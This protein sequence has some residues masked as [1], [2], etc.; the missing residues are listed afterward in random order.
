M[1]SA[2]VENLQ[3]LSL[4]PSAT[5]SHAPATSPAAW[6]EAL[7]ASGSAPASFE[8]VKTL[9]F[10]PKTAKTA[11]TVPVVV[12]AREETETNSGALGKKLKL[13]E[14]RLATA[15]LLTEF[16]AS[17]KDSGGS[18]RHLF[19]SSPSHSFLVGILSITD[20][21]FPKVVTIIDSS[22]SSSSSTFAIH[23][24]SSSETVF[25]SGKD[26]VSYLRK[27]ETD[28]V[29][30]QE[31]DFAELTVAPA[32]AAPAPAAQSAAIEGA[33]QIAIG[34]KKE[35]DFPSWYTSV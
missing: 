13:K 26:I 21:V 3:K 18:H 1:A 16:F 23:A 31:I 11:T 5:V 8:L 27:L 7:I 6:K 2:L 33:V 17:D 34:V 35:V 28:T 12:V 29:K 22:I 20:S 25:L 4:S 30:V 32:P 19:F 9:V 24:G 14:L 10:K 15:D